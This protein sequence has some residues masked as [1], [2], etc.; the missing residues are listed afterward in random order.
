VNA[1]YFAFRQLR[2]A[3][4]PSQS[5]ENFGTSTKIRLGCKVKV[6]VIWILITEAVAVTTNRRYLP[7]RYMI[8]K[9]RGDGKGDGEAAAWF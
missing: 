9:G 1:I 4:Q 6:K 8:H 2:K 5:N 3:I 7:Q